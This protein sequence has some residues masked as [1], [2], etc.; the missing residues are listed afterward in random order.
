MHNFKS[1][2][3]DRGLKPMLCSPYESTRSEPVCTRL[4][5]LSG[6]HVDKNNFPV[7]SFS[8]SAPTPRR[9]HQH[10]RT[11]KDS[12]TIWRR[13]DNFRTENWDFSENLHASRVTNRRDWDTINACQSSW[14]YL[15]N[16]DHEKTADYPTC[17]IFHPSPRI[18]F[19]TQKFSFQSFFRRIT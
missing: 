11:I 6:I 5:F 19:M 15:C 7:F 1:H 2:S 4:I 10:S 14:F 3:L 16:S 9:M 17:T 8:S 18:L 12:I 13:N